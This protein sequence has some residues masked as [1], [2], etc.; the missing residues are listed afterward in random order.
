MVSNRIRRTLEIQRQRPSKIPEDPSESPLCQG[1]GVNY[2][3]EHRHV[4][5]WQGVPPRSHRAPRVELGFDVPKEGHI[6]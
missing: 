5:T 6:G 4:R 3:L 2:R 1:T